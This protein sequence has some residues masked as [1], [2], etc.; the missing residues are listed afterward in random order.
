MG[1]QTEYDIILK[2]KVEANIREPLHIGSSM[3][4]KS[5]VLVHPVTGI[6]FIQ[7]SS[8]SGVM[9][10][11]CE[12]SDPKLTEY[13]FGTALLGQSE[14]NESRIRISDGILQK[15]KNEIKMELRP[16][17][18]ITE[19]T[20][21]VSSSK[22]TGSG[23][24]SGHKFEMLL[25]GKGQKVAFSCYIFIPADKRQDIE[26]LMMKVF[27]AINGEAIQIG[28]Q[29]SNGCG[30]LGID[31]LK[32]KD[33]D[34]KAPDGRKTWA[35]EENE[36]NYSDL[37]G[38]LVS[39]NA[40]DYIITME[41]E[42]DGELLVKGIATSQFG[43]DAPDAVNIR[44]SEK[45]YIIPGSSLKGVLRS[46]MS[47]IVK[48]MGLDKETLFNSIFGNTGSDDDGCTGNVRFADAVIGNI[49]ENDLMPLRNH[50]HIDKLTGGVMYGGNFNEKNTSG[51]VE[52]KIIVKDKNDPLAS[53]G[54]LLLAL[55]DL[56]AETFTI[57]SGSSIGKGYISV[58][59]I[60]LKKGEKSAEILPQEKKIKDD[61][62]MIDDCLKA[63][64]GGNK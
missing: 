52:F 18:K 17:V 31:S 24:D 45:E 4:D 19:D 32:Y 35:D 5:D 57:G 39:E 7:A 60:I 34:L 14:E 13:L 29:K 44:N 6:P 61:G 3:G 37:T 2:Y 10:A 25:V 53:C 50:I 9:R 26:K 64:K 8:L 20:G 36:K 33:Y 21:T 42:T 48:Y 28:G 49:E 11:Y 47:R 46:R 30:Y 54:L 16:R 27:G 38:Q 1:K 59:R 63:L 62:K 41:G 55:R 40:D 12:K 51:K 56:A 43:K 15:N 22:I 23:R 58:K